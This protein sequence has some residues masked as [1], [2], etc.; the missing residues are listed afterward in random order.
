VEDLACAAVILRVCRSV[1]RPVG[2]ATG[3]G[4]DDQGVGVQVPVGSRIFTSHVVQT[5]SRVHSAYPMGTGSSFT[6]VKRPRTDADN[7]PP[8]SVEVRKTCI[9]PL[10]HTSSWRSS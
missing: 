9:H 4:L 8:T 6:G 3:Y 2:I 10:P 1:K 7:S 5:G